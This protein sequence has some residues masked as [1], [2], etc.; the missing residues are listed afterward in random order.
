MRCRRIDA[1]DGP[2][3]RALA[4]I[5]EEVF[6]EWEREPLEMM[7]E[8]AAT[9]RYV[10]E[11]GETDEGVVGFSLIDFESGPDHALLAYLAV[12]GALQGRG[13]GAALCAQAVER[14]REHDGPGWLFVEAEDRQAL[15]YGR[16]GFSHLE[17]DYRI[18]HY[19]SAEAQPAHLLALPRDPGVVRIPARQLAE[20]LKSIFIDGYFV[21][22]DDPRLAAQ[23]A[24]LE[25][26]ADIPLAPWP[27]KDA[28][29][30][31]DT[32]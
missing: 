28:S 15:Y 4:A 30:D 12:R 24:R 27:W 32:P 6:P 8:R 3:W 22:K 14:F 20:E 17:F 25:G 2:A 19:D 10:V 13:Y 1:Q 18:P 9:G 31:A 16:L 11:I 26:V 21:D 23:L 29:K 5:Y 7:A